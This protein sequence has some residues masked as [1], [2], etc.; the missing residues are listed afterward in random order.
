MKEHLIS[1]QTFERHFSTHTEDFPRD[2][3]IEEEYVDRLKVLILDLD[4][5]AYDTLS[6]LMKHLKDVED[7]SESNLMKASNLGVVFSPCLFTNSEKNS[8]TMN[9]ELLNCMGIQ[10]KVTELMIVNFEELFGEGTT[11]SLPESP[12]DIPSSVS[13]SRRNSEKVNG[14]AAQKKREKI[15]AKRI[16][17]KTACVLS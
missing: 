11:R 3:L 5:I 9:V 7:Q 13:V 2:F 12:V 14:E 8:S 1:E 17:S 6:Y 4:D 15:K 16:R 10:T